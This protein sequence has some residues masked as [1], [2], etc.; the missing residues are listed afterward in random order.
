MLDS[1]VAIFDAEM[2]AVGNYGGAMLTIA[3]HGGA[4]ASDLFS[5]TGVAQFNSGVLNVSG[6]DI[7]TVTQTGGTLN[8]SFTSN[9]TQSL[10]NQALDGLAY[11]NAQ[12]PASVLLDWSFSDGALLATGNTTVVTLVG[13][14]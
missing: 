5:A 4:N 9:A 10:V 14:P 12:A 2:A 3:R 7:G 13:G 11:D 8:L 6:T 1:H